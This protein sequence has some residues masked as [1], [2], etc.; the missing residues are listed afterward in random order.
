L[1]PLFF[2]IC[3][4]FF[5]FHTFSILHFRGYVV[6]SVTL[7]ARFGWVYLNPLATK[8]S[9]ECIWSRGTCFRSNQTHTRRPGRGRRGKS[10]TG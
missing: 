1:E 6:A 2:F 8:A 9:A 10:T 7:C 3:C 4:F 5:I